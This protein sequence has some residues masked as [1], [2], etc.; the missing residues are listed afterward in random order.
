[1]LA[2]YVD[3]RADG[4]IWRR[5]CCQQSYRCSSVI[6]QTRCRF[7]RQR[8]TA[9]HSR[10]TYVVWCC[11]RWPSGTCEVNHT[12][13]RDCPASLMSLRIS[14]YVLIF[15]KAMFSCSV[16]REIITKSSGLICYSDLWL[17]NI[18]WSELTTVNSVFL[19]SI[20]DVIKVGSRVYIQL[21]V[22]F[23]CSV[24]SACALGT[25][26]CSAVCRA[27]ISVNWAY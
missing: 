23:S 13:K 20:I 11:M 6:I 2:C 1:M 12:T 4:Q 9:H 19:C 18:S 8:G 25:D 21:E 22:V 14:R 7:S 10:R 16:A 24:C 15:P 17:L 27:G 5:S 3:C 26:W